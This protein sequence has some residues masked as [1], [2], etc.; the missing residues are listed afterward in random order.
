MAITRLTGTMI[1]RALPAKRALNLDELVTQLER[2]G[3]STDVQHNFRS[4]VFAACT[5]SSTTHGPYGS[6]VS[7][8]T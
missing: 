5:R 8:T 2:A 6:G 4:S 1:S 7:C 3:A